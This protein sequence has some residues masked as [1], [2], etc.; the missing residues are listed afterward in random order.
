MVY[1]SRS[2]FVRFSTTSKKEKEAETDN[3]WPMSLENETFNNNEKKNRGQ[4][5]LQTL[6]R[7]VFKGRI[8]SMRKPQQVNE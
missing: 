2:L 4:R 7:F 6:E 3:A 8:I 5:I 1:F